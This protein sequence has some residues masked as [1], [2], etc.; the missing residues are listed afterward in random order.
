MAMKMLANNDPDEPVAEG[1]PA[2]DVRVAKNFPD[3]RRR[4]LAMNA[5]PRKGRIFLDRV[6]PSANPRGSDFAPFRR[7][8]SSLFDFHG[9]SGDVS[10][11]T[12]SNL[13]VATPE[14]GRTSRSREGTYPFSLA[15]S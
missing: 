10:F 2:L 7:T 3:P 6:H 12:G 9:Q 4:R 1:R 13:G 5:G 14:A 8:C 11:S 15:V